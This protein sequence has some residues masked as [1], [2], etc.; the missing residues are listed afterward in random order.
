MRR[1]RVTVLQ[2]ISDSDFSIY[3]HK[4]HYIIRYFFKKGTHIYYIN[5]GVGDISISISI[6][7]ISRPNRSKYINVHHHLHFYQSQSLPKDCR[8][9]C[10]VRTFSLLI[11]HP[12]STHW[13]AFNSACTYASLLT[14]H[15]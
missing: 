12:L 11:I 8:C 15:L 14:V 10:T 3:V 2:I 9:T 4:F 13:F 5:L 6:Y 1:L 7:I